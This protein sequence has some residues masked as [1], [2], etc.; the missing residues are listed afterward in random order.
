MKSDQVGRHGVDLEKENELFCAK[1]D[2]HDERREERGKIVA[3][4][5]D[6]EHAPV[7]RAAL[8]RDG[9]TELRKDLM[10]DVEVRARVAHQLA[11]LRGDK[12]GNG[13][14]WSRQRR[15]Q[16]DDSGTTKAAQ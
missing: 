8:G 7:E 1:H 3:A 4:R 6:R 11:D 15:R 16:H 9:H 10:L 12:R 14:D 13:R 2:E 5:D